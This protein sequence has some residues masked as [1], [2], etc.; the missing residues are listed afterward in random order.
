MSEGLGLN[1]NS[2]VSLCNFFFWRVM[3]TELVLVPFYFNFRGQVIRTGITVPAAF[4]DDS[5]LAS[6]P[7][8]N[9]GTFSGADVTSV[10]LQI[11]RVESRVP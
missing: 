4:L 11:M 6:W 10:M 3:G 7:N 9:I 1:G 2:D 5:T 8:S